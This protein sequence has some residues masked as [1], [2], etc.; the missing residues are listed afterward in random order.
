MKSI[1]GFCSKFFA[2]VL[3]HVLPGKWRE[4]PLFL[5]VQ[6][7]LELN[8]YSRKN[9]RFKTHTDEKFRYPQ[10]VMLSVFKEYFQ[11]KMDDSTKTSVNN[12]Q[13]EVSLLQTGVRQIR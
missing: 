2:V 3:A 7:L 8:V 6:Y 11:V 9:W 1:S 4:V 12:W 13:H 5:H 10:V